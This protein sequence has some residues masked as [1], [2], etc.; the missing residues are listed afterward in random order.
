MSF[1][2]PT[3]E[4]TIVMAGT[5]WHWTMELPDF[6]A[7]EGWTLNYYFRGPSILNIAATRVGTTNVYDVKALASATTGLL[8]GRY[9]WQGIV[10]GVSSETHVA[11]PIADDS[12]DPE[13]LGELTVLQNIITAIAGDYQSHAEKTLTAIETEIYNRVNNLKSIEAYAVAGRQISKIPFKDLIR[14]RSAYQA[15]VRRERN[16]GTI[17]TDIAVTF[18]ES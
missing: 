10:S 8:P 12:G 6:P 4:P 13:T 2:I 7:G 14:M 3:V 5:D 18:G 1:T 15:M 16:P 9:S 17:G 11:R